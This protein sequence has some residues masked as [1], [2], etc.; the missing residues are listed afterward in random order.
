[1]DK[2]PGTL[3]GL[4]LTVNDAETVSQFYHKVIGWEIGAQ[5]MGDYEDYFMK[6]PDTGDIIAGI[7]HA[8]GGNKDLPPVWLAYIQVADLDASLAQV[9]KLGGKIM[10]EKK[11][12]GEMGS[13]VL[14]QDPAGAFF[15][16]W[17]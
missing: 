10:S 7:C 9:E 4:D 3:I 11:K 17:G 16:L 8:R 12:A 1:M 2:K 5:K 13:Y 15:M 6:N 14:V